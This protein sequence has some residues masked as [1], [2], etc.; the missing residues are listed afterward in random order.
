MVSKGQSRKSQVKRETRETKIFLAIN[1]DDPTKISVSTGVG[2]FDHM[3]EALATHGRMGLDVDAKGD[4]HI[5]QHHVVED[6]GIALGTAFRQALGEDL[7][8]R[9]FAAA[10]AP[11]DE[12]LA[13]AVVDISGR[14][15]LHYGV[16]V[17]RPLIGDFQSDLVE[18]FFR[19]F[20][21][22][23][24]LNLHL[25]LVRGKN[26]HHEVE[27]VFKAT[28]LALREAVRREESLDG[29]LSTKGTLSEEEAT[30]GS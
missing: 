5:D 18:E 28:A 29:V 30:R 27:A 15:Y 10:Y 23:A 24:S 13:R 16:E 14:S 21:T 25:D 8:I 6:V 26:A 4:L 1:L 9:R 12:A 19:A 22:N 3:L 7:R 2:F 20:V 11:L 17:S